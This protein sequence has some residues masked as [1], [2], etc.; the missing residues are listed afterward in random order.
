M[1]SFRERPRQRPEEAPAYWVERPNVPFDRGYFELQFAFARALA[2]RNERDLLEEVK[3]VAPAID[4]HITG[5]G[6]NGRSELLDGVTE[7]TAVEIA[8]QN[9]L[10]EAGFTASVQEVIPYHHGTRYGCFSH[11]YDAQRHMAYIHFVNAEHGETGP[12]AKE[13]IAHRE[14]EL[15]DV[16]QNIKHSHPDAELMM[17]R[18][19]LFNTE[20]FRRLFP[21]SYVN[22][23]EVNED[24]VLWRRGTVVWGQFIDS[25]LRVK[26]DLAEVLL[27]RARTIPV[28]PQATSQLLEAP[29]MKPVHIEGPIQDFYDKY[30]VD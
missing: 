12:L 27:E 21:E 6:A 26:Q 19:W 30:G 14:H 2:E 29:L 24:P 25:K 15:R 11:T 3:S 7:E 17:N 1:E 13:N 20:A 23:R 22:S 4:R 16:L 8:Y 10:K 28:T 9:Y 5:Y 18:S